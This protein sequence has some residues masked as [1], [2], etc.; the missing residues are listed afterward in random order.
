MT[1]CIMIV[2]AALF[3]VYLLL[4]QAAYV[5]A[6]RQEVPIRFCLAGSS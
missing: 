4:R 1:I 5:A 3:S 6:H 2:A